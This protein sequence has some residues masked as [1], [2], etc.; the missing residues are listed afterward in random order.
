VVEQPAY[1][2]T[3]CGGPNPA[4]AP[5]CQWCGSALE[6]PPLPSSTPAPPSQFEGLLEDSDADDFD[7][8]S[9][10][11]GPTRWVRIV[12]VLVALVVII[13]VFA[14]LAP[15]S[16]SNS[17]PTPLPSG[18]AYPVNV[19]VI[20][21]TSPDNVCG[22]NGATEP[23][24]RGVTNAASGEVWH[25]TGPTGGCTI[26]DISAETAGFMI[27]T[28]LYGPQSIAAGQSVPITVSFIMEQLGGPYTG[29]LVASVT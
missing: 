20:N 10:W 22:L 27:V 28:N 23:G 12:I 26:N 21:L 19:T 8:G 17:S 5:N 15:Q 3:H 16:Q 11:G 4:Y 6:P 29:P 9:P 18:P 7:S 14:T 24:F 2:C 1:T 25:I 13:A